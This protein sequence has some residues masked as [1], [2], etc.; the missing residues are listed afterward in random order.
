M[1]WAERHPA[2]APA[3]DPGLIQAAK[4][5]LVAHPDRF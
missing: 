3:A 5:W 4:E 1:K 2:E